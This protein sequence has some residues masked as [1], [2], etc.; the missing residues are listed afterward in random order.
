MPEK[1]K[2]LSVSLKPGIIDAV[3]DYRRQQLVLLNR[4][5]AIG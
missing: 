5:K 3:E 2:S 1:P 4:S